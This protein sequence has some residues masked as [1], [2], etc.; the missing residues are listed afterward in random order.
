MH[1]K[2]VIHCTIRDSDKT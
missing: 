1:T 2:Q